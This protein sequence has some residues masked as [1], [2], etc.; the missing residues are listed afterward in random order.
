MQ[1]RKGDVARS[2]QQQ[3]EALAI[4][5]DLDIVKVDPIGAFEPDAGGI[6]PRTALGI[7][8]AIDRHVIETDLQAMAAVA[9][10]DEQGSDGKRFL[11]A[12]ELRGRDGRIAAIDDGGGVPDDRARSLD[13]RCRVDRA[14]GLN[15]PR[16]AQAQVLGHPERPGHAISTALAIEALPV[17]LVQCPRERTGIVAS[18]VAQRTERA[19]GP[20]GG[21]REARGRLIPIH[22]RRRV[23]R[24]GDAGQDRQQCFLQGIAWPMPITEKAID[25]TMLTN[26]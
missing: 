19:Q 22:G 17:G 20:G 6:R 9:G 7:G 12:I 13:E 16:V 3:A 10:P 24:R 11:Q 2:D 25:D 15:Q 4:A 5:R 18:P 26:F 23:A 21:R 1:V 14:R 8:S